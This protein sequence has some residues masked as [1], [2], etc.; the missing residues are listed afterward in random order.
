M[1][2]AV[3]GVDLVIVGGGMIGLAIAYEASARGVAI[4]VVERGRL[5]SGA[6]V[7]AAAGVLSPSDPCEWDGDL[8]RYNAEAIA[9]WPAWAEALERDAERPS[10]FRR[11]GELRVGDAEHEE[12][13][14]AAVRGAER[15]GWRCER[16]DAADVERLAPGVRVDDHPAV[17]LADAAAV[18]TGLLVEAL[19]AACER[20]GVTITTGVAVERVARGSDGRHEVELSDGS[21]RSAEH[22]VVSTGAWLSKLWPGGAVR[23]MLGESLLVRTPDGSGPGLM[24]RSPRGSIVPRG[25]GRYWLGTTLLDRGFQAYPSLGSVSEIAANAIRLVPKLAEAAFLEARSGLRPASPDGLPVL[26]RVDDGVVVA[27][28]HGREGIIHAPLCARGVVAGVLDGDWSQVPGRF[29]PAAPG[30]ASA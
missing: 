3:A 9:L 17:H 6:A 2:G 24:V 28:G 26:G 20:R 11:L 8:G 29:R 22:V 4:E 7:R 19:A 12:F 16:V 14:E 27:G 25:E 18:D 23:P 10:G 13:V 1:I 15:F 5:G 21:R 30:R